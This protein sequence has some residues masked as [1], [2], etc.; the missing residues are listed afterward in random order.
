MQIA[1][2]EYRKINKLSA[3]DIKLFNENRYK[4]YVTIVLG[5]KQ[6]DLTS[7]PIVLGQLCD[8][9]LSDCRGSLDEF[10]KR[11]DEKFKLLSIKKGSGQMFLLVDELFKFTL[12][13]M[14]EEGNI[15]SSFSTRF[16]EAFDKLQS[17]DKFKGKKVEWALEQFRNSDEEIYFQECLDSIGKYVV[18]QSMLEKAKSTVEMVIQD[19]NV[20]WLFN[21]KEGLDNFGKTVIEFEYL[22][23]ECKCEIDDLSI[24]HLN[25]K[26]IIT[27][28][29]TS[30]DIMDAFEYTYLKRRYDLAAAFYYIAVNQ[31]FKENQGLSDYDIEFQFL[32]VDTSKERLRPLIYKLSKDD[33]NK[34]INGFRLKTGS[35]YKGLVELIQEIKWS[36]ETQNWNISEKA[37]E[38]N[39]ILNLEINYE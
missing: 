28:I 20:N 30:Y 25:K 12:R 15:T 29:K 31:E 34:V 9:I 37:F 8:F 36:S 1:K 33:I 23:M 18:D 35:Y 3:S 32:A 13:D 5:E 4:F 26:I 14:D 2:S 24:D 10:D 21:G 6:E 11:F 27:E 38:N 17:Q 16:E 19:E 39:G 22:G 7:P